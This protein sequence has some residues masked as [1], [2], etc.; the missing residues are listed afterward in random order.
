MTDTVK[1]R[2]KLGKLPRWKTYGPNK[3]HGFWI[4]EV[5]NVHE[6]IIIAT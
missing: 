1:L 2:Q 6:K 3:V 4:K 5:T